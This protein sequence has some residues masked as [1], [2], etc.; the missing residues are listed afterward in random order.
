MARPYFDHGVPLGLVRG[1]PAYDVGDLVGVVAGDGARRGRVIVRYGRP[2]DAAA[3][4]AAYAA[5]VG[6]ARPFPDAALAEARAVAA[7]PEPAGSDR[8]DLTG[9]APVT[10]DPAGA[11]DHDDAVEVERI[12]DGFRARI[13][14]ADVGA[15]VAPGS[16]LD[17]E[18]R[19]R[20]FSAYL[21]GRADPMLP[22][23]LSG[24]AASL[25]PG[26]PR[27]AIT[28]ESRFD[29]SGVVVGSDVYRSRIRVRRRLTYDD[30]EAE[31]L[32]GAG[33]LVDAAALCGL[34]RTRRLARGAM[35]LERPD[36]AITIEGERVASARMD[37]EPRAHA[38][39]EELM[40]HAN[41]V[42]AE[43]LA[44]SG[45]IPLRVH[46]PPDAAAVE[47]LY[48]QLAELRVPT[49]PLPEAMSS[50][51]A[52]RAVAEAGRVVSEYTRHRPGRE[53]FST[54]VLRSLMQARYDPHPLGHSGLAAPVYTHFTSPIRRYPDLVV[55][56][57]LADLLD[58]RTP[59]ADPGLEAICEEASDRERLIA[60][61]ERHGQRIAVAHLVHEQLHAGGLGECAGEV[62]GVASA[63]LFVR[64]A[65]AAEGY[66]PARRLPRDWY[67]PSPL[68]TALVGRSS[69]HRIALGDRI[70]VVV[71]LVEP[72]LGRIT[73]D[74]A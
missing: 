70:D 15:L 1:G 71:D 59:R 41:V 20:L 40:L 16:E 61:F 13:H 23:E 33:A 60:R 48:A 38:L 24:V 39:V 66:L 19:H 6:L 8:R 44:P 55:H 31:L 42:V 7:D 22:P 74:L 45:S 34:L 49:P 52:V 46:E 35:A 58:D 43:L 51:Q 17:R 36:L 63:G 37:A 68:G 62:T 67:E 50:A 11:Q 14:I 2:G 5:E 12:G 18:A 64:F 21:P 47:R 73:L 57:A 10:I 27:D 28:V 69:G 30:A 26:R 56:R 65:E 25:L 29:A 72:S 53:P 3:T 4:L 54:L 9:T 32:T